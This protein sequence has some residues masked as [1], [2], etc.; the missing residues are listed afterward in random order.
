MRAVYKIPEKYIFDSILDIINELY[1]DKEIEK[2]EDKIELSASVPQ[3]GKFN[4]IDSSAINT[5][6]YFTFVPKEAVILKSYNPKKVFNVP[7]VEKVLFRNPATIV[8]FSD[9]TK[10]VAICGYDDVYD[11]ETGM[12]I[13]LCK[14]MLGNKEYRELMDK[15]CYEKESFN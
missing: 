13:C 15:W 11:K 10:S 2:K 12:A 4:S 14:R 8:W 6:D 5:D 7:N 9:G 3:K 1:N